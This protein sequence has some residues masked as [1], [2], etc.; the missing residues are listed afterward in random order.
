MAIGMREKQEISHRA[1][2]SV[3]PFLWFKKP[4]TAATWFELS[5]ITFLPLKMKKKTYKYWCFM[6]IPAQ[7]PRLCCH[8]CINSTQAEL[9]PEKNFEPAAQLL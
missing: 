4:R 6:Q 5:S 8:M 3:Q 7:D 9:F 1:Q 2:G